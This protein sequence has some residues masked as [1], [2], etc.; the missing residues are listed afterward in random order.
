MS[1]DFKKAAQKEV[2][3][4][5]IMAGRDKLET[6]DVVGKELT[7]DSFD[8]APKFN[9]NGERVIDSETGEPDE[10]GVVVFKEMPDKYYC[11]GTVFTNVCKVWAS[12]FDTV[13]KASA[14]LKK[15]GGV[16]VKFT[17]SKTKR[18]N[19]LTSVEILD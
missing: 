17:K 2:T 12:E 13:E 1:F 6:E 16:R 11:V 3:L 7:I 18:G 19:N 14:E 8:F 10:F 4:S 5:P 15:S 9:D